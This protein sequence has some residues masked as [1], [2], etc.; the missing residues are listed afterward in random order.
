VDP[1]T[2][3]WEVAQQVFG[4]AAAVALPVIV[5]VLIARRSRKPGP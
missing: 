5:L 3:I 4:L 2:F 1:I